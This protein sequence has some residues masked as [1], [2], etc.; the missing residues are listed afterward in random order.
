MMN[1]L[2]FLILSFAGLAH[3]MDYAFED[4]EGGDQ[5]F[6][7]QV[8]NNTEIVKT[9]NSIAKDGK[10]MTWKFD[11]R[12]NQVKF[13]IDN[14]FESKSYEVEFKKAPS[15]EETFRIKMVVKSP[16]FFNEI[17]MQK[18]DRTKRLFLTSKSET[19]SKR[20]LNQVFL[21]KTAQDT[22]KINR[23][24]KRKSKI[25]SDL[26]IGSKNVNFAEGENL[27][28]TES[29]LS[30]Y[31]MEYQKYMLKNA[32]DWYTNEDEDKFISDTTN[33]EIKNKLLEESRA[34]RKNQ[35]KKAILKNKQ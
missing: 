19:W 10:H 18:C 5:S 1:F 11:E 28:L 30:W 25:S 27:Q 17:G 15:V 8:T 2:L 7:C 23:A 9:L 26:K 35:P 20:F 31:G 34:A 29:V 12:K 24:Y 21:W 3:A 33:V 14:G 32:Q 6:V 22:E 4:Y 13:I 16:N